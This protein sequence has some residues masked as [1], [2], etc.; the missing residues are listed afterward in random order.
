MSKFMRKAIR[1]ADEKMRQGIGDGLRHFFS[2]FKSE[3]RRLIYR[4]IVRVGTRIATLTVMNGSRRKFPA[5]LL[6]S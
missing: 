1:L 2:G 5:H 4:S 3:S 6:T